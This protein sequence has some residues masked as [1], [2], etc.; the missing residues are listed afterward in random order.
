L[1]VF[2]PFLSFCLP[3]TSSVWTALCPLNIRSVQ[4][5]A[6]AY[7]WELYRRLHG[8]ASRQPE[9]NLITGTH[10]RSLEKPLSKRTKLQVRRAVEEVRNK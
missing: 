8:R 9:C 1:F 4:F 7:T 5:R 10:P 6:V 2:S 3:G